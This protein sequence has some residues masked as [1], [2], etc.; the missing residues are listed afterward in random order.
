[1]QNGKWVET[2]GDEVVVVSLSTKKR[3]YAY[4][5]VFIENLLGKI[6]RKIG[7]VAREFFFFQVVMKVQVE[8]FVI[9]HTGKRR[10]N[11]KDAKEL[12][13]KER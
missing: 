11:K 10:K 8:V 6:Y 2:F 3:K 7:N 13:T 5:S 4:R 1:M 9:G 12:K